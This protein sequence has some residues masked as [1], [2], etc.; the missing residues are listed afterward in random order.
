MEG[1]RRRGKQ[2]IKETDTHSKYTISNAQLHKEA[3]T[4]LTPLL[5]HYITIQS[6][7]SCVHNML[8]RSVSVL[9]FLHVFDQTDGRNHERAFLIALLCTILKAMRTHTDIQYTVFA[10]VCV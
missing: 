6:F 7:H 10:S 4:R 1:W 8:C 2:T 3:H 5:L 9:L